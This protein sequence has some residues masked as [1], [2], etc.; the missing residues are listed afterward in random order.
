MQLERMLV[1]DSDIIVFLEVS[2]VRT[3]SEWLY[4]GESTCLR[5]CAQGLGMIVV[6][7]CLRW[8]AA[9]VI[10]K[11]ARACSEDEGFVPP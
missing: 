1:A 6:L 7:S 9:D 3:G 10:V 8:S 2:D 11:Y 5:M 4:T